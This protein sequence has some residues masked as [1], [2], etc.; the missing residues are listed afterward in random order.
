MANGRRRKCIITTLQ[1]SNGP[2]ND[3]ILLQEHVYDFYRELLGTDVPR[4]LGLVENTWAE[5]D[6]V[7]AED[8]EKLLL[9]FSEAELKTLIKEMKS[10]TAPGPDGFPMTFFKSLWPLCRHG[11]IGRAHV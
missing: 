1:S 8:N 5:N 9:T 11:E 3:P 6:R 10:N 2:I 7:S 4:H